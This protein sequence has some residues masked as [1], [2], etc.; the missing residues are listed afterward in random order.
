MTTTVSVIRCRVLTTHNF[1]PCHA[2]L[3]PEGIDAHVNTHF[4]RGNNLH[5]T[6]EQ[7]LASSYVETKPE[8]VTR[9]N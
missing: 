7:W 4:N 5:Q 8:M 9:G 3:E 2:A 6:P 1:V